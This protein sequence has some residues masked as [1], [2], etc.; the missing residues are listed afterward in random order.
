M[1]VDVNPTGGIGS[2]HADLSP[3]GVRGRAAGTLPE[4]NPTRIQNVLVGR[5][6]N[7]LVVVIALIA[8]RIKGLVPATVAVHPRAV[9]GSAG[10]DLGKCGSRSPG[11][12]SPEEPQEPTVGRPR[13]GVKAILNADVDDVGEN[14]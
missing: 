2:C 10:G 13:R 11:A 8:R 14:G 6:H 7:D 4:G 3:R 1:L 5:I 9:V 12:I